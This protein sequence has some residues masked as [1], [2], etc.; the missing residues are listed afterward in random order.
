MIFPSTAI[1]PKQFSLDSQW[2]AAVAAGASA[3]NGS[4]SAQAA[5]QAQPRTPPRETRGWGPGKSA[6]GCGEPNKTIGFIGVL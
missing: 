2:P 5:H 6:E 4:T 3:W 1:S